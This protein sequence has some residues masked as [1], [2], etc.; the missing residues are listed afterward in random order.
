VLAI[1][2]YTVHTD[3][4]QG[5]SD[6]NAELLD[7]AALCG[8]LVP[9]GSVHA[10]L[11][12]HRRALFPDEAFADLFPSGRGRPSVAA[13]VIA[14]VMVL[15]ALE[16]L[17]DRDALH[18]L[19][20]NIAWKA[21]AGLSLADEG[22]HPTVLTLWRNKLRASDRPERIFD[23]VRAVIDATGVI[24]GR[25]RRVLDS[26]V[27]DDAVTTQDAVMQLVSAVRRVRRLVP[28]A[29]ALELTTHDYD[30]DPGKPACAWDDPD[31]L[32]ALI[33]A[34]V[35]DALATLDAVA[36]LDL[37]RAQAEAVGLLALVAGQDVEP[38]EDE[39]TWR[40]IP[41]TTPGR[42]V[43]TVDPESRHIHK[44]VSVYRDGY[45]AHVAVEPDTGLVTDCALTPGDVTDGSAGVALLA[46]E[47]PGLEV[48]AD[49][50][51]GSGDTRAAIRAAGHDAVIKPIPLRGHIPGGFDRD[52]F[53][54]DHRA[55]TVT[56]PAGDVAVVRP[57]GT[58]TFGV[59]CRGCPMRDRCTTAKKGKTVK[60]SDHDDELVYARSA[61]RDPVVLHHYRRHRPMVERTIAWLVARGN[62][63]VA[64]RGV[65]RNG[66]WLA[67]RLG[68]L[69]LRRLINLGLHHDGAGWALAVR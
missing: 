52:D 53:V 37:D 50:A 59:R 46:G 34:L 56:C 10:F 32:D 36:G 66:L 45:K 8:H 55:R 1:C 69:N 2:R 30:H 28:E 43:S 58:A 21:A 23:A 33:T 44:S 61:W 40:I 12:E 20:T 5:T 16:G 39:G 19:R 65:E 26:T 64:Y 27:L 67:T 49:S 51:Y 47:E 11:A 17:S 14:T 48:Y 57:S 22:F 4:V 35:G 15:Q 38:G 41:A 42:I 7:A 25:T 68:A 18:Q 54:V 9:A 3:G 29:K 63:K 13:D 24:R 31:G 60:V 62:R 6:P